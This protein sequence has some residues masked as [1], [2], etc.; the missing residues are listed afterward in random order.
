MACSSPLL[1]GPAEKCGQGLHPDGAGLLQ[2][3]R[4]GP[5]LHLE[6]AGDRRPDP[7]QPRAALL[8]G[9]RGEGRDGSARQRAGTGRRR[10]A[11]PQSNGLI[12][13]FHRTHRGCGMD[14][15]TPYQIFK[16]GNPE[17]S[18]PVDVNQNEIRTGACRADL[19]DNAYQGTTVLVHP[20]EVG[21]RSDS[22]A[23]PS[24]RR[25]SSERSITK[26]H[27]TTVGKTVLHMYR[28]MRRLT[29][30]VYPKRHAILVVELPCPPPRSR[31]SFDLDIY[32]TM[33]RNNPP[34][35]L[36]IYQSTKS[37]RYVDDVRMSLDKKI[38][39]ADMNLSRPSPLH[40]I[41]QS[42]EQGHPLPRT[43]TE[44][45]LQ[46]S[47]ERQ[48]GDESRPPPHE[49]ASPHLAGELRLRTRPTMR[50]HSKSNL[51]AHCVRACVTPAYLAK[52][53]HHLGR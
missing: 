48:L 23:L 31:S 12:D 43:S 41:R 5:A 20:V 16:K 33:T 50:Y 42:I 53:V 22:G 32:R 15:R 7:E 40:V 26:H 38:S 14:R 52:T 11:P 1:R 47:T 19:R 34:V 37:T 44:D 18:E 6:D 36:N 29:R 28:H 10:W 17:A 2:P 35:E 45:A 51:V 24:M 25:N 46:F 21:T 49:L 39:A 4:V 27:S 9:A 8:R 13:R 3:L 30:V